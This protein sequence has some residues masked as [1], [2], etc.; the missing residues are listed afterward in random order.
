MEVPTSRREG[1]DGILQKRER[2]LNKGKDKSP[3][4][5]DFRLKGLIKCQTEKIKTHSLSLQ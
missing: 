4:N 5:K 3:R 1:G 2:D